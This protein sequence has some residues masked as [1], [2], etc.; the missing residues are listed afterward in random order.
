MKTK[1]KLLIILIATFAVT[2]IAGLLAGCIGEINAFEQAQQM[3]YTC[4]VTYYTNGGAF[5]EKNTADLKSYKT[6]YYKPGTP[7][8]NIIDDATSQGL[9][10]SRENFIFTGWEYCELEDGKPVLRGYNQERVDYLDNGS[11]DKENGANSGLQVPEDEK[12]FLAD[13]D[14]TKV[15]ED[16]NGDPVKVKLEK[17]DHIFIGATWERDN[18]LQFKL[19]TDEPMTV[20]VKDDLGQDEVKTFENGDT[21][22]ERSFSATNASGKRYELV[23][24]DSF[25]PQMT[26]SEGDVRSYIYLYEDP[27]CTKPLPDTGWSFYEGFDEDGEPNVFVYAK[28]LKGEWNVIT[29]GEDF[30]EMFNAEEPGNYF[31]ALDIECSTKTQFSMKDESYVFNHNVVG[32]SENCKVSKVSIGYG[33]E[34]GVY[35]DNL[36]GGKNYSIFGTLGA[37]AKLINF[38]LEN[39]R[40]KLRAISGITNIYVVMSDM[41]E[42]AKLENFYIDGISLTL[43]ANRTPTTIDRVSNFVDNNNAYTNTTNW[44]YGGFTTDAEFISGHGDIVKNA[45]LTINGTKINLSA[46]EEQAEE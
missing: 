1:I 14:G 17:G 41:V 7:I 19:V 27:E 29:K 42:G 10:I 43:T 33:P 6:V 36:D 30:A 28:Y 35:G 44:L 38:T 37:N 25:N 39:I 13:T 34:S 8:F 12:K 4:A 45:E 46:A 15:F 9:I 5:S 40:L 3:G 26:F 22:Y 32:Y 18:L 24:A 21:F 16:E 2:M 31:I 11:I 20:T 23:Y